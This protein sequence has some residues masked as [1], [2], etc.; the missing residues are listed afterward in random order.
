VPLNFTDKEILSI[1]FSIFLKSIIITI[2]AY[3]TIAAAITIIVVITIKASTAILRP[4]V[5]SAAP[6]HVIYIPTIKIVHL[7]NTNI[8]F[9]KKLLRNYIINA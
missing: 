3:I 1:C 8:L 9:L 6:L 4:K 2:A 5:Y 7:F